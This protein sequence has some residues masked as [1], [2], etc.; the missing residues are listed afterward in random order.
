MRT[1]LF[2]LSQ[3]GRWEMN[4]K[5]D[6]W[7]FDPA[8]PRVLKRSERVDADIV[9][10][11][12]REAL[13]C[14]RARHTHWVD[15]DK[16]IEAAA[17]IERLRAAMESGNYLTT[18]DKLSLGIERQALEIKSLQ[19]EIERLRALPAPSEWRGMETYDPKTS[20][21][22]CLVAYECGHVTA[23]EYMEYQVGGP[24]DHMTWSPL[25]SPKDENGRSLL[26]TA[27]PVAWR[28]YPAPPGK[29]KEGG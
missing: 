28:P 26:D 22:I 8:T 5:C 11:L 23:A 10:W 9:K 18:N 1:T 17:E 13:E 6:T 16:L 21:D 2:P 25:V 29:E 24:D 12:R 19:D 14:E 20:P 15:P 27:W 7:D 4:D 3:A